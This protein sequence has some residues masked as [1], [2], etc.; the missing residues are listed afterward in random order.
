LERTRLFRGLPRATIDQVSALS[1]RHFY[2]DGAIAFSQADPGDALYGVITGKIRIS[3]SSPDGSEIFLN[4][5]R[6]PGH[7]GHD[8]GL[9][10]DSI[11]E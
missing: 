9:M 3:A 10:A 7:D 2:G 8:S 6:V 4:I 5:M 11:P 1:T